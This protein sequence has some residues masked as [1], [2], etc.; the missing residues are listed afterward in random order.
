ML[1]LILLFI[2]ILY[3]ANPENIRALIC[4]IIKIRQFIPLTGHMC[5]CTSF[6]L[7]QRKH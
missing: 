3:N 2:F 5:T 7:E 4:T 6:F 1:A